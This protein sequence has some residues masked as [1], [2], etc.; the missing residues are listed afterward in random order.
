MKKSSD[1]AVF[2]IQV[3]LLE[4][5]A[6]N[7]NFDQVFH[8]HLNYFSLN[9]FSVLLEDIG[10]EL[11]DW[12]VNTRHWNSVIF[13]FKKGKEIS[14][15]PLISKTMLLESYEV[16]KQEMKSTEMCL[17]YLAKSSP[18]YGY[19]AALVLPVITYHFPN[20]LKCLIAIIDDDVNKHGRYYLNLAFEIKPLDQVENITETV[21][22]LTGFS[23]KLNSE[24]MLKNL[25]NNIKPKQ[26]LFPFSSLTGIIE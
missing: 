12:T 8:Q 25:Q 15:Y 13:A 2:F 26:T 6:E 11:I 21:F 14:A 5:I 4:S 1:D 19:G 17:E 7:F 24:I 16:F 3:P 18:I 9:S 22:L 23:S 10:C 20:K